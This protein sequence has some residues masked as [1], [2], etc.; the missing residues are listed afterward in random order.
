MLVATAKEFQPTRRV[1][2]NQVARAIQA[3][4]ACHFD[5]A[6]CCKFRLLQITLGQS[7]A[8][9]AKLAGNAGRR[10]LIPIIQDV[11]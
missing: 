5:E 8:T 7:I 6:L 9:E 11:R 1:P 2:T 10:R 3:A 4:D